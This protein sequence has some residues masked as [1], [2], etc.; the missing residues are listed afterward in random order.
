MS[1]FLIS[2]GN[3]VDAADAMNQMRM[4]Y[5]N[6]RPEGKTFAFSWGSLSVLEERNGKNIFEVGEA[7]VAWVGDLVTPFNATLC[8]SL[9]HCANELGRSIEER[10]CD[11]RYVGPLGQLNGAFACLIA[12]PNGLTIITD[13]LGSV[14]VYAGRDQNGRV[15]SLGTHPDLVACT[16]YYEDGIDPVSVFEFLNMGTPCFPHTMHARVRELAPGRLHLVVPNGEGVDL[17]DLPWWPFPDEFAVVPGREELAQELGKAFVAAVR[18]RCQAPS[19]GVTLSGGM[20]S[21]LV[22]A[23][24]PEST[25]CI[26]FTFCDVLNREA[27]TAHRVAQCYGRTWVPLLRGE[28]YISRNAVQTVKF[29]GCEGDWVNAH[30][31]G[32]VEEMSSYDVTTILTGLLMNNNVKGYYAADVK[33]IPRLGGLLPAKYEIGSYDYISQLQAFRKALFPDQLLEQARVRRGTFMHGHPG[34]KRQSVAEWL[35]GYPF[36]QASDNTAWVAERRVLPIRLPAMDRRLLDIAARIPMS[37]KADGY[38]FGRVAGG[39]LGRGVRIPDANDGVRPGSSHARRLLQRAL[40]KMEDTTRRTI[41]KLG[42]KLQ[43]Q[44]SWHDYQ[45]YWRQNQHLGVLR[46]EY[47]QHLRKLEGTVFSCDPCLL[48]E[49]RTLH[50]QHGFRLLQL[51]IW[52][53]LLEDYQ[54]ERASSATSACRIR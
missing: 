52:L 40:R 5:P 38:L 29:I 2:L 14:Q 54:A 36:S 20:D 4:T 43:I 24:I 48:L 49:D 17:K 13:P 7:V 51:A 1:D 37:A 18:D 50:W 34:L 6:R 10:P 15:T 32:F 30:G 22:M 25:K 23:A 26:G 9:V 45:R 28:D 21:R 42:G 44:G 27:R 31:M 53:S 11:V 46:H 35:D 16:S 33:R 19:V 8:E 39:I 3:T 12:D 41:A 47:G